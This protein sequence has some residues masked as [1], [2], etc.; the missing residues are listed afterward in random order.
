[1]SFVDIF[2]KLGILRFGTKTG[3]YTSAKDMPAEFMMDGIYNADKELV[4]KQ[5]VKNVM[6]AVTGNTSGHA[7]A[8]SKCEAAHKSSDEQG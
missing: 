1:M 5:D 2:R 7:D 8:G 3:T 4:T 6:A